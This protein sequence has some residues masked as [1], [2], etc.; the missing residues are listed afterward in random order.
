[1][2]KLAGKP[3]EATRWNSLAKER[4]AAMDKYLWNPAKGMYFDYDYTTRKQSSYVYISAL[5]P[6]WAGAADKQQIAGVERN[7]NLLE[8]P[9]GIAMS[10]TDSGTQWD[11]PFGW[12][13]S[14]WIAIQGLANSGDLEDAKRLSSKFMHTIQDGFEQDQ[15]IREKYNVVSGNSDVRVTTGY[16][17]NVVGFGWTNGVY[18]QMQHLLTT[19]APGKGAR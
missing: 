2:A 10:T 14:S 6:L 3:A 5:Y 19:P 12:A 13:P 17:M 4:K 11:L 18:L 7:L 9:G 15:T 1:M 8:Q 16:K